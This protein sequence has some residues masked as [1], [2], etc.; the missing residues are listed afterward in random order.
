MT[1]AV[2]LGDRVLMSSRCLASAIN[3]WDGA[4]AVGED[5]RVL[6]MAD[7]LPVLEVGV[8]D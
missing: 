6:Y 7:S 5:G 2:R 3:N 8:P 4:T 1:V